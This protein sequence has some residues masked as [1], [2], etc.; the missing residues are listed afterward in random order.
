MA[1]SWGNSWL[2]AWGDSWGPTDG[3]TPDP[4][5]HPTGGEPLFKIEE[6]EVILTIINSFLFMRDKDGRS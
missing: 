3:P 1:S 5:I 2:A 4:V 6:E